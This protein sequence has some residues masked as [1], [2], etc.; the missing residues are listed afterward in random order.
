MAGIRATAAIEVHL[1]VQQIAAA[2]AL[3]PKTVTAWFRHEPGVLRVSGEGAS[4][5]TL[6]VPISVVE[7]VHAK[8]SGGLN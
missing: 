5:E 7:R 6:R 8:R 1:T 3:D 2:W 4:R